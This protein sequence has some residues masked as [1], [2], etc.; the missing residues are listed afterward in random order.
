MDLKSS[1]NKVKWRRC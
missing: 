1:Q